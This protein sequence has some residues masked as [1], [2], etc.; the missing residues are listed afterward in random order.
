MRAFIPIEE[1]CV[2]VDPDGLT[3]VAPR[4]RREDTRARDHDRPR[5]TRRPAYQTVAVGAPQA[6]RRA[7]PTRPEGVQRN[8]E[9]AP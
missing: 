2:A 4:R 5:T 6:L 3:M 9:Q 7:P 8:A 1:G